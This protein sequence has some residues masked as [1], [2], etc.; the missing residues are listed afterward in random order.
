MTNSPHPSFAL[1]R[2]FAQDLM[3]GKHADRIFSEKA[4]DGIL[5]RGGFKSGMKKFGKQTNIKLAEGEIKEL[6]SAIND[7]TNGSGG[8]DEVM[9]SDWRHFVSSGGDMP[10]SSGGDATEGDQSYYSDT[11]GD[12]MESDQ[13]AAIDRCCEAF[14]DMSMT[15]TKKNKTRGWF[16]KQDKGGRG[17]VSTTAFQSFLKKSEMHSK[18]SGRERK[19]L[20]KAF[21]MG[22]NKFDYESFLEKTLEGGGGGE[23]ARR[24][25]P[26]ESSTA[27]RTPS[28]RL[29]GT[30]PTGASSSSGRPSL[31]P[32]ASSGL[33]SSTL[34]GWPGAT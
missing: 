32:A 25:T 17:V 19:T 8:G 11:T 15:R 5:T 18:L 14:D 21:E 9:I 16:E 6:F 27:S 13:Q 24:R 33:A 23:E 10:L 7:E 4:D 1:A 20:C 28:P 3:E 34:S 31:S 29:P 26:T 30:A 22:K 12:V 2:R